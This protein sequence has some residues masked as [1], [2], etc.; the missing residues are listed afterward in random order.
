MKLILLYTLIAGVVSA[1]TAPIPGTSLLLTA[2]EVYMIV[3]LSKNNE[4]KLG[5]K[6]I[7]YSAMALYGLSTVLKDAALEILTFIP[8]IGWAAEVIVAMLFVFFL[9]MLANL[10]FSKPSRQGRNLEN[11]TDQVSSHRTDRTN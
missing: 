1:L 11:H 5:L 10:Y 7:G 3:H 4:A 2:L 8:V 6:E 9:G